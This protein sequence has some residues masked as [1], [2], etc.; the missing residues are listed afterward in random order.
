MVYRFREFST[1][2]GCP[3]IELVGKESIYSFVAF[4]SLLQ[5]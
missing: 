4:K 3:L 1:L 5:K 2:V